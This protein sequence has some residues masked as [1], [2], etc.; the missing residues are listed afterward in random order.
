MAAGLTLAQM[1][2]LAD[3]GLS[4]ADA[5]EF[6]KL[7]EKKSAGAERTAR[8]RAKKRSDV[9]G[10]VTGDASP[11]PIDNH[12][13]PVSSDEE[14]SVVAKSKPEKPEDVT[15]QTW[16]DF[17]AHRAKLKFPVSETALVGIRREADKANWSMEAALAECVTRGWRAFKADWVAEQKSTGPPG[18]VSYLDTIIAQ[19]ARTPA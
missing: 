10:D 8:W 18:N 13:P 7:G 15:V 1:E 14:T 3:K 4:L 6:A 12:T 17:T 19:N 11:P 5:I 9:T 2:F 16:R